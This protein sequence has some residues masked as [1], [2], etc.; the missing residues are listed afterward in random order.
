[1][2]KLLNKNS[3][4]ALLTVIMLLFIVASLSI[5]ALF[6]MTG[7]N[8]LVFHQVDR[9]KAYYV[10]EAG[11]VHNFD[12]IAH[13]QAPQNVTLTLDGKTFTATM[14]TFSTT[15]GSTGQYA[16]TALQSQVTY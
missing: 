13:G 12:R 5:T 4:L 3:G 15:V 2:Q 9:I 1:M 7:S 14:N 6:I 10:A 16:V 8:R 11:L